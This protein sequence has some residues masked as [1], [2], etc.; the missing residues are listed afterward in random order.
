MDNLVDGEPLPT[1]EVKEL[2][3][4][5]DTT[6]P[7]SCRYQRVS[8]MVCTVNDWQHCRKGYPRFHEIVLP[9]FLQGVYAA[10]WYA[11]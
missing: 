5:K 9:A 4:G 2:C 7:R 3:L 10:H 6:A 11:C 1:E 8:M